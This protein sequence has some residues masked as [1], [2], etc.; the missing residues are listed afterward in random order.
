MSEVRCEVGAR[1]LWDSA[2]VSAPAAA[3]PSGVVTFLFTDVE[4]STRRWEADAD[5]MRAA[6]AADD[7]VSGRKQRR[8]CGSAKNPSCTGCGGDS[9]RPCRWPPVGDTIT[10]WHLAKADGNPFGF[11]SVRAIHETKGVHTHQQNDLRRLRKLNLIANDEKL[12]PIYL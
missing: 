9:I 7:E 4:G 3:A 8:Q 1:Q 12:G 11:N 5:G 2:G 10:L 6:L